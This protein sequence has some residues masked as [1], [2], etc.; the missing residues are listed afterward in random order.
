[1]NENKTFK[2]RMM[3]SLTEGEKFWFTTETRGLTFFQDAIKNPQQQTQI[4]RFGGLQD[5]DEEVGVNF[6]VSCCARVKK[7][8]TMS[9]CRTH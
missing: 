8:D 6:R 5:D 3:F 7:Y 2:S 1:M 9:V 4:K